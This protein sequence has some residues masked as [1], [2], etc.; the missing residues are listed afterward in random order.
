M[1]KEQMERYF[2]EYYLL[3]YRIAFSQMKNRA[4][5]EDAAQEVFI[6]LLLHER[7]YESEEHVRAWVTR[8]TLNLCK[9]I[10]KSRWKKSCVG[11]EELPE[12]ELEAAENSFLNEDETLAFVLALP[13]NYKNCLYLFYYEDYS[14]KEFADILGMQENTVKTN[15]RR[16][17]EKLKELLE[18]ENKA[19]RTGKEHMDDSK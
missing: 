9:D 5:A 15:L 3:A 13:E 18:Q 7:E 11:I 1:T 2:K 17:R 4:D 6:R 14:F 12:R 19:H 10:Q 16:G 8:V